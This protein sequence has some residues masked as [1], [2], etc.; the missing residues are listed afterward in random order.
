M[1]LPSTRMG[2]STNLKTT[3]QTTTSTAMRARVRFGL[4]PMSTR[5]SQD[6]GC[7][8]SAFVPIDNGRFAAAKSAPLCGRHLVRPA[9][10]QSGS[11]KCACRVG[12]T[13][14]GEGHAQDFIPLRPAHRSPLSLLLYSGRQ[15]NR[16]DT[17]GRGPTTK[18]AFVRPDLAR[19][20]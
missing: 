18:L 19:R 13:S 16:I 20:S 4:R 9:L 3:K 5:C 7:A 12:T 10:S 17:H 11:A 8:A 1:L 14:V 15:R 6:G 2:T